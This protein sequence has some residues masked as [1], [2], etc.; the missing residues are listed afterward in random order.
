MSR[1]KLRHLEH[2]DLALAVK[3]RLEI[4]IRVDLRSL[5]LVLK[6]VLLDVVPKLLGQL[7]AREWLGADNRRELF[8]RLHRPH[9]GGVRLTLGRSLG[10]RH[11]S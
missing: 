7:R 6:P 9:E 5:F 2:A 3:Y 10:F 4:V 11:K 8:I 1:D